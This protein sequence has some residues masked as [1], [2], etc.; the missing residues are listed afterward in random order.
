MP[1]PDRQPLVQF[2]LDRETFALVQA[3]VSE[4]RSQG[5]LTTVNLYC[6]ALLLSAL[7]QPKD[8]AFADEIAMMAHA[9]KNRV[10][11]EIGDLLEANMQAIVEAALTPSDER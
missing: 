4:L 9:A 11:R 3:R 1:N 2:R 6:R 7:G 5:T 8:T 10:S